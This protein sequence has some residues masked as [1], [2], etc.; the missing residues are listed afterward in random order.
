MLESVPAYTWQKVLK[1]P[2]RVAGQSVIITFLRLV[3]ETR[4]PK[5][6]KNTKSNR[7]VPEPCLC[8]ATVSTIKLTL[9]S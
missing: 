7:K 5:P 4:E 9:P 2:A 1:H 6:A 3:E 8:E